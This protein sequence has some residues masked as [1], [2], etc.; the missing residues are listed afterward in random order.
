MLV[1]LAV[2]AGVLA[3]A[4]FADGTLRRLRASRRPPDAR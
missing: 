2:V 3:L 1:G 4:V